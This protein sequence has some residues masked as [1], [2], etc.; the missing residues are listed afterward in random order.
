MKSG[1]NL[2]IRLHPEDFG[3]SSRV[4]VGKFPNE[5]KFRFGEGFVLE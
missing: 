4:V 5:S 3:N 1:E 2:H